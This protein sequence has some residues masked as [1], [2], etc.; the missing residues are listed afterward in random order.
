MKSPAREKKERRKKQ[1]QCVKDMRKKIFFLLFLFLGSFSCALA[2]SPGESNSFRFDREVSSIHQ[3]VLKNGLTVAV[4]QNHK[5][6]LVAIEV[7]CKTGSLYEGRWAGSGISHLT[8]HMLFKGTETLKEGQIEEK[9]K[10]LGGSI[11]GFTDIEVTG[12]TLVL[13]A[14]NFS[15]GME[16]LS[17]MIMHP[18]YDKAAISREKDVVANEIRMNLDDPQRYLYRFFKEKAF[19]CSP[20]NLPVIGFEPL[21]R[22]ITRGDLLDFHKKWYVPNNMVVAIAGDIEPDAAINTVKRLFD[23]FSM[24][25]Y[26]QELLPALPRLTGENIYE[27][28]FPVNTSFL[29]LGFESVSLS[30]KDS[31]VLDVLALILGQ[32]RGSLLYRSLVERSK[33]AFSAYAYNYTPSFNG[34]FSVTAVLDYQNKDAVL[35]EIFAQIESLKK[36]KISL[37]ELEK[38][39]NIYLSDYLFSQETVQSQAALIASD[40]VYTGDPYF[41]QKYISAVANISPEDLQSCARK[42]LRRE[43]SVCVVLHPEDKT[44]TEENR[45]QTYHGGELEEKVLKNGVRVILKPD[46]TL[47]TVSLIAVIGGGVRYENE[48]DNGVFNELSLLLARGSK[49]Y[50]A[51]KL[52]EKLD[53]LGADLSG[54]SG[55]NS[56][57]ITLDLLSK[58]IEQGADIFSD[59]LLR[60][61]FSVSKFEEIKRQVINAVKTQDDDIFDQAL[62][63]LRRNLFSSYPYRMDPSGTLESIGNITLENIRETHRRFLSSSNLV[64][65]VFGDF[66]QERALKILEER[67]SSLGQRQINQPVFE[68]KTIAEPKLVEKK[69]DKQ[70]AVVVVGFRAV[71]ILSKERL[72]LEFLASLLSSPGS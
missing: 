5:Q 21:L 30:D 39:K 9:V 11:N 36:K 31:A 33:L 28:E 10:A 54:F 37:R 64:I 67:F 32:K 18:L 53:F 49:K 16:I 57:G 29:S 26:P 2:G 22:K 25:Y 58:D 56:Y 43:D 1:E 27:Q 68:E 65:A 3:K 42:Y 20:Y 44:E 55:Y 17:D 70:Q 15:A 8:E 24:Q 23:G 72:G 7:L 63:Q 52:D 59:L 34:L 35:A 40:I 14:K 41:T 50:P 13:P 60:P 71:D 12:Y 4:Q 51:D 48:A 38:A 6:G 47:P 61:E 19:R 62:R 66:D 46:H 69:A 45:K